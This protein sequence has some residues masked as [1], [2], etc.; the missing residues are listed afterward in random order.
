MR[1]AE[2]DRETVLRAAMGA[3]MVNGYAKNS[4]QDLT[5]ATGLHPGSIYC[6]FNNKKGLLL[7]TIGQYQQ[8][9]NLQFQQFF[10]NT[11]PALGNLHDY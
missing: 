7:A 1:N 10:D 11:K 6:A 2:F 4:M 9:K 3:F 8:D 5:K